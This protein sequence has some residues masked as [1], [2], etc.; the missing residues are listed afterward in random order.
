ME[1]VIE[2]LN[3][4][5]YTEETFKKLDDEVSFGVS[6]KTEKGKVIYTSKKNVYIMISIISQKNRKYK[7]I[8]SSDKKMKD[9]KCVV[10]EK[11][12]LYNQELK[13]YCYDNGE[14]VILTRQEPDRDEFR[15]V[16][17]ES[18]E[19]K[20]EYKTRVKHMQEIAE[21]FSLD[22][23]KSCYMATTLS[24][25]IAYCTLKHINGAEHIGEAEAIYIDGASRGA[26]HYADKGRV[27]E[28]CFDYDVNSMYTYLLTSTDFEFPIRSGK[29][30]PID[31]ECDNCIYKLNVLG[32]HRFWA[33]TPDNFYNKYQ[34]ELLKLLK[35]PYEIV[36]NVK[37]SYDSVI[38]AS[39]VFGYMKKIY[40]TKT[41]ENKPYVK[42]VLNTTWGILSRK[43]VYEIP[44]ADYKNTRNHNDRDIIR[45]DLN[46]GVFIMRSDSKPYKHVTGRL[47][48]FLLSYSRLWIVK[49]ILIPLEQ[50]GFEIYQVNT[51][52]FI[53]NAKQAE[54]T[55]IYPMSSEMGHLKLEKEFKEKHTIKHVHNIT[56]HDDEN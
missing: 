33:D 41:D 9:I 36:G 3:T 22:A 35:I 34:M 50:K 27:I 16:L 30:I 53:T 44:F 12:A 11:L 55:Q 4:E 40:A 43:K 56:E 26:L 28:K 49:N 46:R 19:M 47:K 25:N 20:K 10:E 7:I 15:I 5:Q 17:T 29:E 18:E 23:S 31:D 24:R 39:D 13:K 38:K 1:K 54:M 42:E 14:K 21:L 37:Y 52:G 6:A 2:I 48:T 45:L 32:K 51:D 8:E